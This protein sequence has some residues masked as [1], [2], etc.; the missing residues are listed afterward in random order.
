[1]SSNSEVPSAAVPAAT[2]AAVEEKETRHLTLAQASTS[3]PESVEDRQHAYLIDCLFFAARDITFSIPGK[4]KK[5]VMRSMVHHALDQHN[6]GTKECKQL[7]YAAYE[8]WFGDPYE[9]SDSET[10]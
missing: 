8:K 2:A 3:I 5:T 10:D 6:N 7:I 9:S 1:M 4:F